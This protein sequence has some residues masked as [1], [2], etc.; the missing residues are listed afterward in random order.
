MK[1]TL[2]NILFYAVVLP[3]TFIV[4]CL[5]I[6]MSSFPPKPYVTRIKNN[7]EAYWAKTVMAMSGSC[8]WVQSSRLDPKGQYIFMVNHQSQLDI[9]LLGMVLSPYHPVF[10]AKKSLF[11]IPFFGKAMLRRGHIPIA[12]ENRREAMQSIEQAVQAAQ[13]G[14]SII[15]FPEGTRNTEELAD[16]KI[17]GIILALKTQLP[18]VPVLIQGTGNIYPKGTC[19]ITP[20]QILVRILPPLTLQGKYSLKDR[21]QFKADLWSLMHNHFVETQKWLKEKIK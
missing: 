6:I 4:S 13:K 21:E 18:V 2:F 3:V 1:K 5:V 9:P 20:G 11:K 7:L 17:G 10:V 8:I 16:F 19:C 12:R 14:S 15:I